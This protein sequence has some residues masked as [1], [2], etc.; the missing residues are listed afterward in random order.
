M[1]KFKTNRVFYSSPAEAFDNYLVR[2]NVQESYE[3]V[4]PKFFS[5]T[6]TPPFFE[7]PF[8]NNMCRSN[9][10]L[11]VLVDI[12]TGKYIYELLDPDTDVPNI[13]AYL[14]WFIDSYSSYEMDKEQSLAMQKIEAT[15]NFYKKWQDRVESYRKQAENA[16]K[17]QVRSF[18]EGGFAK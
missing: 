6:N 16:G 2:I 5:M 18:E 14:T 13:V 4:M 11:R 17:P 10:P 1:A 7:D 8:S 15:R 3:P 12:H 9:V